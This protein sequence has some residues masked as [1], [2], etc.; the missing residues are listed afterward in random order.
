MKGIRSLLKSKDGFL[1]L[2]GG[3]IEEV[4]KKVPGMSEEFW[5]QD[6]YLN[7]QN[8]QK[9]IKEV[10]SEYLKSGADIIIDANHASIPPA[11]WINNFTVKDAEKLII[12]TTK[13]ATDARD[14]LSKEI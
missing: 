1:L 3:L 8:S 5:D 14:E 7:D 2:S 10:H 6:A 9:M 12:S 11:E 13:L 4:K